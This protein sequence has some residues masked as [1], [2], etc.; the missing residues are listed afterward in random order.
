[1]LESICI[2]GNHFAGSEKDR[3]RPEFYLNFFFFKQLEGS[4]FGKVR[5]GLQVRFGGWVLV[6][7]PTTHMEGPASA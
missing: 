7:R 6:S 1:M 4:N 3:R 2:D 5:F